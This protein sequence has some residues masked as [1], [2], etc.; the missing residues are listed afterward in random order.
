MTHFTTHPH[1][2]VMTFIDTRIKQIDY[3]WSFHNDQERKYIPQSCYATPLFLS[4]TNPG[5]VF[6]SFTYPGIGPHS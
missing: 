3:S 4:F 5:I 2:S 1:Q 6:L